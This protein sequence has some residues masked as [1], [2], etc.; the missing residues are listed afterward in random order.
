MQHIKSVLM[1]FYIK[2]I[3]GP[4][5]I[6]SFLAYLITFVLPFNIGLPLILLFSLLGSTITVIGFH[7]L[8]FKP[9]MKS[10]EILS[11]FSTRDF[12]KQK[13]YKEEFRDYQNSVPFV[14]AFYN[15]TYLMLDILMEM[16]EKLSVDAGK[17]SMHTATLSGSIEKLSKKLEENASTVANIS[18]TTQNIMKNVSEVS[19]SAEQATTFTAQT[20]TRK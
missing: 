12:E 20:M 1:P 18:D 14:H 16:A 4:T 5:I 9:I 2:A 17:N 8:L 19:N 6:M 3:I 7:I 11:N 10:S 15:K 13:L